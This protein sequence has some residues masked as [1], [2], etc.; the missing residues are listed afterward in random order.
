MTY[1][2]EVLLFGSSRTRPE[3]SA[4]LTERGRDGW[5]VVSGQR[6]DDGNWSFVIE[7]ALASA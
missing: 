1:A 4:E 2:Y 7:R 6:N 3:I 5:R